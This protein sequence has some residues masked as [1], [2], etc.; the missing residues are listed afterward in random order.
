[1]VSP[2]RTCAHR[3]RSKNHPDCV[4]C[5]ERQAAFDGFVRLEDPVTKTTETKIC[6]DPDCP[7]NGEP[8]AR[9]HF[10]KSTLT[11]DGRLNVCNACMGRRRAAGIKKAQAKKAKAQKPAYP[12]VPEPPA[13]P[14]A[15]PATAPTTPPSNHHNFIVVD[16][17]RHQDLLDGLRRQAEENLRTPE[18]MLLYL[19]KQCVESFN[20][21]DRSQ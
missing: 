14:T 17:E 15:P 2:C 13:A 6:S 4:N 10:Q 1:M 18:N 3:A 16:F 11:A 9:D 7:Y 19:V 8:Q 5:P 12:Y 20:A 21:M